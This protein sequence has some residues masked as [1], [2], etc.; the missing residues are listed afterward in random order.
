MAKTPQQRSAVQHLL[1]VSESGSS[2]K[3]GLINEGVTDLTEEFNPD[4]E[5]L[6]YVAEDAKTSFVKSYAPSISISAAVVSDDPVCD[7]IRKKINELPVGANSDT[8]YIRF[9]LLDKA[10]D[11]TPTANKAYYIGYRRSASISIGNIGGSAE[12][13]LSTEITINGKGDQTK[14]YVTVDK[15][16]GTPVYTWSTEKPE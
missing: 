6:K 1:L 9:C 7:Y 13:Y 5:T 12:D 2:E 16:T 3:W 10:D 4:E 8:E 14:G 15:T 11:V